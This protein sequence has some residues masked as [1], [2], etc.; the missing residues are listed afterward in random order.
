MDMLKEMERMVYFANKTPYELTRKSALLRIMLVDG[1]KFYNTI[2]RKYEVK[3]KERVAA[4]S[5]ASHGISTKEES[6][7]FVRAQY[8]V[9]QNNEPISIPKFLKL[10]AIQISKEHFKEFEHLKIIQELYTVQD[11]IK[12]V[13][14][15]H[16]GVHFEKLDN[17][18]DSY[19]STS[20]D[21]PFNIN[22]NSVMHEVLDNIIEIILLYLSPL[23]RKVHNN[24]K[25]TKPIAWHSTLNVQVEKLNSNPKNTGE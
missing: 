21:S 5:L 25:S 15:A 11:V 8:K 6:S 9:E 23:R 1:D 19:F 4:Y 10:P 7:F 18:I 17:N 14:N 2:N 22:S 13:A 24:L 12:L 16:G 20:D 3:L